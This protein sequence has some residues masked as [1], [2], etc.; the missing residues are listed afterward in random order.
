MDLWGY[1]VGLLGNIKVLL[2]FS[3]VNPLW[4]HL[5]YLCN[6][7]QQFCFVGKDIENY[8]LD[9][10][11]ELAFLSLYEQ[12]EKEQVCGKYLKENDCNDELEKWYWKRKK[13][14]L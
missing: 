12:M 13:A 8:H 7:L 11:S 6:Y 9:I 3:I 4:Y 1:L 2:E 5:P 14:Q 10:H